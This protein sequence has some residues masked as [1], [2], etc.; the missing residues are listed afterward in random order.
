MFFD[1]LTIQN[2]SHTQVCGEFLRT[3]QKLSKPKMI[4]CCFIKMRKYNVC[5]KPTSSMFSFDDIGSFS[6]KYINYTGKTGNSKNPVTSLMLH[7]SNSSL[8]YKSI[9]TILCR[10]FAK[11]H[12]ISKAIYG[13]LTSSKKRTDL[14]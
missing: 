4:T 3:F 13:L 9:K 5:P 12:L 8:E 7:T 14:I 10:V 1:S 6:K 2:R 11:G